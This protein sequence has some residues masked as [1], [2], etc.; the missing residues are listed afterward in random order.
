MDRMIE[1][2][3]KNNILEYRSLSYFTFFMLFFLAA[4]LMF[5][6]YIV[7]NYLEIFKNTVYQSLLQND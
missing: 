3:E 6:V 4:P 7:P 2:K 1:E 5:V